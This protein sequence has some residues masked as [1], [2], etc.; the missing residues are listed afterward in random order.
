MIS[1]ADSF[2]G[3][4]SYSDDQILRVFSEQRTGHG[5]RMSRYAP[6]GEESLLDFQHT[7]Q[8]CPPPARCETLCGLIGHFSA[9]AVIGLPMMSSG[10]NCQPENRSRPR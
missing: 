8:H 2:N 6:A 5:H 9:R 10:T 1:T 7:R 3:Q 4:I